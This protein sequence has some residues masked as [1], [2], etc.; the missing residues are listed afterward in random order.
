M[1]L[2]P[3]FLIAS[4]LGILL[5]AAV[6]RAIS[7]GA[8]D[9]AGELVILPERTVLRGQGARQQRL[10]ERRV[11]G[12]FV[13]VPDGDATFVSSDSR[14][15]TVDEAGVVTAVGDGRATLTAKAGERDIS[16]VVEV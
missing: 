11:D 6:P 13:G 3:P 5:A 8:P 15:A 2:T 1:K 12:R 7:F 4:A 14:V 9:P 10:I 16:T